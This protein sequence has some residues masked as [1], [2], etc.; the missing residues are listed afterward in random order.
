MELQT[1]PEPMAY[2]PNGLPGPNPDEV[3]GPF[4]ANC[5][6]RRL[7]FQ[8]CG[9]C[10]WRTHPPMP[11]C[12]SCQSLRRVW[13]DAP[14]EGRVFSF[15]WAHTAAHASLRELQLPYN[16][17]VVEFPDFPGVRLISNVIDVDMGGLQ[18]GD[19][20]NL[21]WE[22]VEAHWLPRFSRC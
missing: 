3:S 12:P 9:D 6:Q 18:I 2:L 10:G 20:L 15:I 11:V 7:T 5:N 1:D 8:T 13:T 22:K 16:V 17:V 19:R 21:L 14:L 4:W